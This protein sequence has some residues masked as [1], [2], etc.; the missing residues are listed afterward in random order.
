M[1]TYVLVHGAWHGAWCWQKIV[2]ALEAAGHRVDAVDLPGHGDDRTPVEGMTLGSYAQRV[3]D[4]VA[5]ADE[6]VVLLGHSMGGM[7]VTQAAEL[8]YDRIATLVYLAAFLPANGQ[9]LVELASGDVVQENLIV[10]EAA[11]TCLVAPHALRHAFYEECSDED[12]ELATSRLRPESLAALVEPVQI[13]EERAGSVP[14]AYI[15]C[16]LDRAIVIERQRSMQAARPCA[17]VL[18]IEADHSPFFSRPQEL[19]DHLLSLA[20]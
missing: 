13:T 5:A 18:S 4:H 15:E 14:R 12:F 16:L 1:A 17:H 2:P 19:I 3:A 20:A 9:P 7:V 6:P 11:G 8:V 10:D